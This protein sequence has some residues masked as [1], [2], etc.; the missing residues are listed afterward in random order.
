ML[1]LIFLVEIIKWLIHYETD[2][3]IFC[4][5]GKTISEKKKKGYGKTIFSYNFGELV[6]TAD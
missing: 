1:K 3:V 6:E 4:S 5:Y 2:G